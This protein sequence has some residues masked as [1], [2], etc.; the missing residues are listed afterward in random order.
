MANLEEILSK[1]ATDFVAPPPLPVGGYRC[2]VAGLPEQIVSSKKQTPG[3]RFILKPIEIDEDVDEKELEEIGGLAE[4]TIRHDMWVTDGSAFMLREFLEHC[5]I[6]SEGKTLSEM[7][8]ECPNTEVMV[9][10][11]HEP[12]NRGGFR[13]TIAKTGPVSDE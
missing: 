5:G 12:N 3:F 1:P 8:D 7:I 9:Y 11:K 4:K 13:A 2:V 10:I 6:D